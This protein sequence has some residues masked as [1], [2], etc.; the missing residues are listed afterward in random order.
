MIRTASKCPS[1]SGTSFMSR[2]ECMLMTC[3]FKLNC[4]KQ[5]LVVIILIKKEKHKAPPLKSI[6]CENHSILVLYVLDAFDKPWSSRICR[7]GLDKVVLK[8]ADQ[9]SCKMF[10]IYIYL[11]RHHAR[12]KNVL[13]DGVQ[14]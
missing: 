2:F 6:V 14:L 11:K 9:M 1:C 8:F 5:S 4:H 13:S 7:Y 12:I 10:S 3:E